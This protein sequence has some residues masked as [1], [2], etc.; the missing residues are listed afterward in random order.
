[1]AFIR[2][3]FLLQLTQFYFQYVLISIL[4]SFWCLNFAKNIMEIFFFV[5]DLSMIIFSLNFL[6][7]FN[8]HSYFF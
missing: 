8:S 1:M 4:Y 5:H 6:S 7:L 2:S 3:F